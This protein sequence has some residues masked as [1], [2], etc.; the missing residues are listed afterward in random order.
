M[1]DELRKRANEIFEAHMRPYDSGEKT[2]AECCVDAILAY[3]AELQTEL[4][5]ARAEAFAE[6]ARI[7]SV[8]RINQ[9]G[10]CCDKCNCVA[11]KNAAEAI[12]RAAKEGK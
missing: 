3:S 7:I 10:L 5:A 8:S 12:E 1:S 6:C 9:V 4:A 2:P 11:L